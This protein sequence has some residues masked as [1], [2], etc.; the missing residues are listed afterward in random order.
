MLALARMLGH[1]SAKMTLETYADPFDTNPDALA[2]VLD[3]ARTKALGLPSTTIT[4]SDL[5][6]ENVPST[7]VALT[8]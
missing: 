5:A 2:D 8:G 6:G 4:G 3:A 7:Q 1:E